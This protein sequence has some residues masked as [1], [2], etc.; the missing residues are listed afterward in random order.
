MWWRRRRRGCAAVRLPARR[1]AIAEHL[2]RTAVPD[3]PTILSK[4]VFNAVEQLTE[5]LDRGFYGTRHEKNL[6]EKIG[7]GAA[8]ALD[9]ALL[10]L[11]HRGSNKFT[12]TVLSPLHG[13]VNARPALKG[14]VPQPAPLLFRT[15]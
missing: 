14:M 10:F 1:L 3:A 7:H 13:G 15:R 11:T 12:F 5:G 6:V 9:V 2:R 4:K 8:K